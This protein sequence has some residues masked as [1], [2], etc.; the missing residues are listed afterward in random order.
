MKVLQDCATVEHTHTHTHT[1]TGF[2]KDYVFRPGSVECVCN[3]YGP[4]GEREGEREG[5]GEREERGA[6]E[7]PLFVSCM[8]ECF[9]S[10]IVSWLSNTHTHTH[11]HTGAAKVLCEGSKVAGV[12]KISTLVVELES[13]DVAEDKVRADA[14]S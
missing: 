12:W 8:N 10:S 3:I 6:R 4:A 1:H 2:L 13:P 9:C 5:G 7:H 14:S 11:T